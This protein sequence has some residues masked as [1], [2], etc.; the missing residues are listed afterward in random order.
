MVS[1]TSK[2]EDNASYNY[3]HSS[4]SDGPWLSAAQ[5]FFF[6]L[7]GFGKFIVRDRP[8]MRR[9]IG[10][11]GETREIP[12]KRKVKFLALGKLR[13]L[14]VVRFRGDVDQTQTLVP[15]RLR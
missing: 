7:Y 1:S 11:I 6:K 14:E 8:L 5:E 2:L 15:S 10:F 9:K 4:P 13:H 12:P 3:N